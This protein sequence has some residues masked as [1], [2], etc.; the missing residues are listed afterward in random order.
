MSMRGERIMRLISVFVAFLTATTFVS[1]RGNHR[2]FFSFDASN[3]L[4]D[5]S[6]QTIRCTKS[7][8]M[9]IT[10]IGHINFYDGDAFNHIDP[11]S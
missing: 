3:G 9:I 7:G 10:T 5:N 2:V 4:A 6:A 11:T 1:A 8:R